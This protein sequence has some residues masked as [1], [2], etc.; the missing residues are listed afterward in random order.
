MPAVALP[1]QNGAAAKQ[2][3]GPLAA[4]SGGGGASCS[5]ASAGHAPAAAAA[6]DEVAALKARLEAAEARA[7]QA[8]GRLRMWEDVVSRLA[9]LMLLG[10]EMSEY[11]KRTLM[12]E[13][14]TALRSLDQIEEVRDL[15]CSLPAVPSEAPRLELVRGGD[16]AEPMEWD[17]LWAA[18]SWSVSLSVSGRVYGVGFSL[19]LRLHR[20]G[21]RGRVKVVIPRGADGDLS[22]IKVSFLRP[23]ELD[24][25]VDCHVVV[26]MVPL[27]VRSQV[28]AKVRSS[29]ARWLECELV[30]P[31]A[32]LF[33]LASMRPKRNLSDADVQQAIAD[34]ERAGR[35]KS[36]PG[37]RSA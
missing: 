7:L 6:D 15:K 32:M 16:L 34:A 33:K 30:E 23:P 20:F 26:G 11:Y 14:S 29:F 25:A 37:C 13:L 27:P 12:K 35:T 5:S 19:D 2:P 1:C 22:Q 28:D 10:P 31:N 17:L 8:E 36:Q 4:G 24:V 21:V 3:E 9:F 18:A